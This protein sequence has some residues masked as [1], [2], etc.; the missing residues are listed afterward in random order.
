MTG[1]LYPTSVSCH[2]PAR[3][4]S[5]I[6]IDSSAS[7]RLVQY[8][9]LK[10]KLD[11][12]FA[13]SS[14]SLGFYVDGVL[15]EFAIPGKL[16]GLKYLRFAIMQV[17]EKPVDSGFLVKCLY[18]DAAQYFQT[19]PHCIERA[20]RHAIE[21]S[22]ANGGKGR[23]ESVYGRSKDKRPTNKEFIEFVLNYIRRST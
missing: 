10:I 20:V 22:W 6:N 4:G 17:L 19:K 7:E 3:G 15:R 12:I 8:S 11:H 13:P 23:Y 21:G 14:G 16:L 1:Y 18:I 9:D 5:E 2:A